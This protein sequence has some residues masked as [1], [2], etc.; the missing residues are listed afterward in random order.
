MAKRKLLVNH[1]YYRPVGH[2][3]EG[4][5]FARGFLAA[6]KNLEIHLALNKKTPTELAAGAPWLKKVYPIDLDEVAKKGKKAA[7]VAKIPKEWD[8]IV[9]NYSPRSEYKDA[10]TLDPEAEG[11][12][13]YLDIV[14]N[15]LVSHNSRGAIY[16]RTELPKSLKYRRTKLTL[17]V[18]RKAKTFARR[19]RFNG[20]KICMLLGGSAGPKYYPAIGSWEKVIRALNAEFP[21]LRVYVTGVSR[22]KAGRTVT[23]AYSKEGIQE[24][25]GKFDNV[26]D[27]Y[28]IGLW[29]QVALLQECDLLIAP[30]S[31]FAF[32]AS[33]VGRPWLALSGGNWPEYF[34]NETPFYSVL[35]DDPYFPY[36]CVG[37]YGDDNVAKMKRKHIPSF[38]PRRF[39]RRI[40]EIVKGVKLLLDKRFTYERALEWNKKN[41]AKCNCIKSRLMTKETI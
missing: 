37:R 22:Q 36:H 32:L 30:H 41:I 2:A 33:C 12:V 5:K 35:P 25:I 24:L 39:E 34:F 4:L 3:L 20:L 10:K 11:L 6:N 1:V 38:E 13:R 15:V 18:P 19:Y 16:N 8:Y 23:K 29:N 28:D 26:V 27:C 9:T 7:C 17:E 21:G 14:D 31:G 40:P